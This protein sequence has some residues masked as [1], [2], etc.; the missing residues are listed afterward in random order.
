MTGS[1]KQAAQ[2]EVEAEEEARRG[3]IVKAFEKN[4]SVV[5]KAFV[6]ALK[7]MHWLTKEELLRVTKEE[8]PKEEL[9]V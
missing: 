4:F 5:R 2:L 7:I 1:H 9:Q 8:L 6:S 3:G